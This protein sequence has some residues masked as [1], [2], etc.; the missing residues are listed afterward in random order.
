MLLE[1]KLMGCLQP[2]VNDVGTVA[3]VLRGRASRWRAGH[4]A[5]RGSI[6]V[7]F[8]A[9]WFTVMWTAKLGWGSGMSPATVWA[10]KECV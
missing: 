5:S 4:G 8:L 9:Q 2:W 10:S 7:V 6:E 3:G 1:N